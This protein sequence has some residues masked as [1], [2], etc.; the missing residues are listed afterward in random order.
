MAGIRNR[1]KRTSFPRRPVRYRCPGGGSVIHRLGRIP[2]GLDE[3][4]AGRPAVFRGFGQSPG[5]GGPLRVGEHG[6][7][8]LAAQ[9]ARH[10]LGHPP[11]NGG[12]PPRMWQ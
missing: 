7:V 6:Q 10:D 8:R 12:R 2:H 1:R 3:R 5:H 9:V 4:P 11:E